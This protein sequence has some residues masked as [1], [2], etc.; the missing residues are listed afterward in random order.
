MDKYRLKAKMS[1]EAELFYDQNASLVVH[2]TELTLDF[3]IGYACPSR[4]YMHHQVKLSTIW[5]IISAPEVMTY[6]MRI[7]A[8]GDTLNGVVTCSG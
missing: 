2:D 8:L 6:K 4:Q 3:Q 7:T 5:S 1:A